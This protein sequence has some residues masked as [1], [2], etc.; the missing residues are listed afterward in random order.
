MR[1]LKSTLATIGISLL[2]VL[3]IGG[4]VRL[5]YWAWKEKYPNASV[6]SFIISN[7]K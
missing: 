1:N 2:V 5:Q 7:G 3:F 6:W 4:C